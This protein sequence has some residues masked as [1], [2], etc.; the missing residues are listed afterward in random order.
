M[1]IRPRSTWFSLIFSYR[2][3]ILSSIKWRLIFVT[4]L[5]VG[6]S[7]VHQRM[8]GL[9]YTLTPLPF[10]LIG[11]A[12]SIFLGFRNNT[13]YDRFWEGRKL[14]GRLVNVS[15]TFARQS[16]TLIQGP[17]EKADGA[18]RAHQENL[19]RLQMGYVHSLRMHLRGQ[20]NWGFL[21]S[22]VGE[23]LVKKMEGCHN[24]P[25]LLLREISAKVN[26]AFKCG[27]LHPMHLP[28]LEASQTECMSVQGGCERI[29]STPIPF[30]YTVLIHRIVILYCL[31]L[32]FGIVASVGWMTAPVVLL[33]AFAFF[34]LDAIGDEIE[35]PFGKDPNDLPLSAISRTI[36]INLRQALGEEKVPEFVKPIQQVLN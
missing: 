15:R 20:A 7:F 34:G 28:I 3:S 27:W 10:Q 5:A 31:G 18:V 30:S 21:E 16:L 8:G 26:E 6:V 1:I 24:V 13:S 36:E 2:G 25:D 17:D 35:D 14:W 4:L 29:R 9:P 12:L 22:F 23:E 32:P 19:V 11:L 33:I